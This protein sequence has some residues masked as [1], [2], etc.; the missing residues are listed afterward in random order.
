MDTKW[1]TVKD[2]E[3]GA[4]D[5]GRERQKALDRAGLTPG[6]QRSPWFWAIAALTAI[7][8][9]C[10]AFLVPT[11]VQAGYVLFSLALCGAALGG[12]ILLMSSLRSRRGRDEQLRSSP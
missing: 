1:P 10:A 3:A 5:E 6:W 2:V 11:E 12:V 4:E 7:V 8:F 9:V